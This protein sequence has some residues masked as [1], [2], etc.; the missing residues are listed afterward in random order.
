M[1][2]YKSTDKISSEEK[3][4]EKPSLHQEFSNVSVQTASQLGAGKANIMGIPLAYM[5]GNHIYVAPSQEK[6]LR[7]ELGHVVQQRQ[8]V[9]RPTGVNHD[10]LA[11]G[12]VVQ[13]LMTSGQ[14]INSTSA[15]YNRG[16]SN[17][18]YYK[19]IEP[20]LDEYHALPT[21]NVN[22][23]MAVLKALEDVVLKWTA[24]RPVTNRATA[25]TALS[26]DINN[27]KQDLINNHGY[28]QT[29]IHLANHNPLQEN[30]RKEKAANLFIEEKN[31][32]FKSEKSLLEITALFNPTQ[33][34]LFWEYLD[35]IMDISTEKG[36]KK[37]IISASENVAPYLQFLNFGAVADTNDAAAM[38]QT[39]L[40]KYLTRLNLLTGFILRTAETQIP[41]GAQTY[42]QQYYIDSTG[43]DPHVGGKHALFLIDKM[44]GNP[45]RV[46]KPH[47]M[48]A[49]SRAVGIAEE[50]EEAGVAGEVEE[51]GV[52][53]EV[54]VAG[55]AEMERV[56]GAPGAGHANP[57]VLPNVMKYLNEE[58]FNNF[59]NLD[60]EN[61]L[62]DDK[63]KQQKDEKQLLK[64]NVRFN[65]IGFA[66]MDDINTDTKTEPFM[67]KVDNM[68]D[69]QAKVYHFNAGMLRTVTRV[70][71][72]SD[73]HRDNI[74][75]V[76]IG[77]IY[78]PLIIDAECSFVESQKTGLD[79]ALAHSSSTEVNAVFTVN[80]KSGNPIA[81]SIFNDK[82][83]I[84]YD[85]GTRYLNFVLKD[86]EEFRDNLG[87]ITADLVRVRFVPVTTETWARMIQN[88]MVG[89]DYI[90]IKVD[91]LPG[92]MAS[93][94]YFFYA[95]GRFDYTLNHRQNYRARLMDACQNGTIPAFEFHFDNGNCY[96]VC[97]EPQGDNLNLNCEVGQI[98]ANDAN[99]G[100]TP[101]EMLQGFI[102]DRATRVDKL[103][104]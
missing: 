75:P 52:A 74:M 28:E 98:V 70:F 24:D 62:L 66:T 57:H 84:F 68:S 63:K 45:T 5:Q 12:A 82:Y 83:K 18:L 9:V 60:D 54:G 25:R 33:K 11:R 39:W 78:A 27:E 88:V 49:D 87:N 102:R 22:A 73:L 55:E 10:I 21:E 80:N 16:S 47:D 3:P 50:V 46:Y 90:D 1:F 38:H 96:V 44:T 34:A 32:K 4:Q 93:A 77:G 29:G 91:A 81:G 43:S 56:A 85:L 86:N 17:G 95:Q 58:N 8:G 101:M 15:F 36:I 40:N 76:N 94:R 59:I 92:L 14:F 19:T 48:V 89:D 99:L 104:N 6:H 100:V 65:Q 51:A 97:D 61:E 30:V 20:L 71:A 26:V 23:R 41:G 37:V 7:H 72:M 67:N 13:C 2:G 35:R 64:D 42:G 79:E 69:A 31:F 103:T 53:R